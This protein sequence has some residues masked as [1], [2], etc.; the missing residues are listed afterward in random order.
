MPTEVFPVRKYPKDCVS[1]PSR[2]MSSSR[3]SEWCPKHYEVDIHS[4]N[5][6]G[7]SNSGAYNNSL[8]INVRNNRAKLVVT[9]HFGGPHIAWSPWGVPSLSGPLTG[10]VHIFDLFYDGDTS[11]RIRVFNQGPYN[12]YEAARQAFVDKFPRGVSLT[13]S[14]EYAF[15][16]FDDPKSDNTGG[17]SLLVK[18]YG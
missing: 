17:L 13:G 5:N 15:C 14:N 1:V 4:R 2:S 12:G 6:A 10:S 7:T 9:P 18:V 16:I 3:I 8:I 11:N